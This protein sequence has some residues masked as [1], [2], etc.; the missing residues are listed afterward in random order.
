M[1][2]VEL[3]FYSHVLGMDTCAMVL[4]PE[5]RMQ[6]IENLSDKKYPVL[7]L[8][9]GHSDDESSYIRKSNIEILARDH[10]LI[11]V[12]P[13]AH[14]SFYC[15]YPGGFPYY[16]YLTEE[17]PLKVAN[18]FHASCKPEDTYVAGLSMGGL[19]A[20]KL[21]LNHPEHFAAV[22]SMSGLL[23]P[24]WLHVPGKTPSFQAFSDP[25]SLNN[26]RA[27]LGTP[28]NF[29][30]SCSDLF[31]L[32]E[33]LPQSANPKLRIFQ[34]CGSEDMLIDQNRAFHTFASQKLSSEYYTYKEIPGIH[35]W[36]YWNQALV[37]V[38]NFFGFAKDADANF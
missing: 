35:N 20:M 9:H 12:M 25:V 13:N 29:V 4:L 37:D 3:R 14:R 10:E 7:Y 18:F 21:A 5:K 38:M 27:A 30:G 24:Y 22:A 36:D 2:C 11:V 1:A 33:K 23:D 6:P 26:L 34:C 32:I 28:E 16:T 19:G 17:L 8:L 15:D 31:S